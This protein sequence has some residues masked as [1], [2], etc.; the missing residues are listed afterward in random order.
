MTR[1]MLI[2]LLI[3]TV[4]TSG[5]AESF[6]CEDVTLRS[7]VEMDWIAQEQRLGRSCDDPQAIAAVVQSGQKLFSALSDFR[8]DVHGEKSAFESLSK[9]A[10]QLDSMGQAE[11]TSLYQELRWAIH[12]AALKNPLIAGKSLVFMKRR[13][14]V[15]QMLHEYLGYYYDYADIEGG[16][17]FVLEKPGYSLAVQDLT[18]V[19]LKRGNF[20]TLSLSYD[21]K[22]IY[23]AFARR[24][25]GDKPDFYST[26]RRCFHIYAMNADGSNLRQITFGPDDDFDPCP[27]PDGGIAFMSSARGGFTRCNNPWEP[28]PAHTLHRLDPTWRKRQTLSYHETSEWHPSVLHD[29]RIVYIR[30]DYVDRSAANFHGLWMTCP[31]GTAT[32]ALFGNYTMHINACYQPRAV[33]GSE[34]IVFIAGAHHADV[35]GSMVLLDPSAVGLDAKTGQDRFDAIEKLTPEVCYPES[36]GW[37]ESYFHSPWPLSED[38]YLVAFSFDPLPGMSAREKK[39]DT[40]TGLYYF[41]RFGNMELLYRDKGISCMY[42]IPLAPRPVPPVVPSMVDEKL[43]NEGEFVV[44]DVTASHFAMPLDRHVAHLRIYQVLPKSRTH[45]AN[46]PRIGHANAESARMLLGTVPV[47]SDGSAYFRVPAGKPLY[48]QAVDETGR[49][50]QSMRSVV[51]LQPGERRSCVGCHEPVGNVKGNQARPVAIQREPSVIE[52]GPEGTHPFSFPILM[53]PILDRHCVRCHDGSEGNDKSKLLLTGTPLGRFTRSYESL[54]PFV[55]WYEWG[56]A[57]IEPIITRPGRIGA[58]ESPL[59]EILTNRTHAGHVKLDG[60]ERRRLYLWLD[61]NVPFYGSYGTDEQ[62]A[63]QHGMTILPPALQ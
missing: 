40:E 47:E 27:L 63:Q 35:G 59:I 44:S 32:R 45:V 55:R 30:W 24:A 56:G 22:T 36:T 13:R 39:R 43:G 23:F 52:P 11:R 1:T 42:P 16:G 21:A 28:L 8:V 54:K 6:R 37:P 26:E 3:L 10:L 49:A 9:R 62:Y 14:F 60:S 19:C 48:F 53:Q 58:D 25:D 4:M 2:W 46:Q 15:C 7:Q 57:S 12:S 38:V 31:D 34:K 61:A 33:P 50:V 20:T 17:V 41:D 18:G 5:R 29:G 51:Y